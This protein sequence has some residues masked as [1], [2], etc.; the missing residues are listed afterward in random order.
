MDDG[1]GNRVIELAVCYMIDPS[2]LGSWDIGVTLNRWTEGPSPNQFPL[3]P[4][5]QDLHW[6]LWTDTNEVYPDV[7]YDSVTGDLYLVYALA[8]TARVYYM[9]YDRGDG[10]WYGPFA[11]HD[12]DHG[13]ELPRIDVGL[14]DDLPAWPGET[15]NVVG[16]VYNSFN[17]GGHTDKWHPCVVYW[18]T[19]SADGDKGD[20]LI[21]L[22]G[23]AW[24]HSDLNSGL[25]EL[26]IAPNSNYDHCGAVVYVQ[27]EGEIENDMKYCIYEIDSITGFPLRVIWPLQDFPTTDTVLPSVALHYNPQEASPNE[28]S[29]SYFFL[30]DPELP[31]P[32]AQITTP[33]VCRINLDLPPADP[34]KLLHFE[35]I[36]YVL[37]REWQPFEVMHMN[38]ALSSSITVRADH[39][40]WV[41]FCDRI[42]WPGP[43]QYPHM[44]YAAFGRSNG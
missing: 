23:P 27:E 20:N 34:G 17:Q 38:P 10:Q 31:T 1:S 29:I 33:Q 11:V 19:E 30:A 13:G 35:G 41:G 26:D 6:E 5:N 22:W 42:T 15:R 2:G 14:V 9:R 40:Y 36:F 8:G 44:V 4:P 3:L 7:A 12:N 25:P 16:V 37:P 24:P 43:G 28:A 18:D 21:P 39:G 32:W